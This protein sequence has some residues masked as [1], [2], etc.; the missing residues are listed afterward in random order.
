M[1]A[2]PLFDHAAALA[3]R[4]EGMERAA[5]HS[6]RFADAAYAAIERIARRQLVLFTDDLTDE[7][8]GLKPNHPN[9]YGS[10]WM[11]AVR[12]RLIQ[13]TKETRMSRDPKKHGHQQP[14]Y[15][16][17]IFRSTP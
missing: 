1:N 14:I 6:P 7:L 8:H 4:D 17:L 2:L 15:F 12:N 13:R 9:C 11:R 3:L 16:S 5:E 10:I